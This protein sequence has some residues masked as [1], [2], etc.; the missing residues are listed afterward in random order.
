MVAG[1]T[2]DPAYF[3]GVVEDISERRAAEKKLAVFKR[4]I[5]NAGEA[6]GFATLDGRIEYVNPSL[7]RLLKVDSLE[8]A[9]GESIIPFYPE[10]LQEKLTGEVLPMTMRD[11]SWRGEL[12]IRATDGRV[13]PTLETYFIID[14]DD[15]EP[16]AHG[17]VMVDL[18]EQTGS[19]CSVGS[20]APSCSR[21]ARPTPRYSTWFARRSRARSACSATSTTTA[22]WSTRP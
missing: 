14:D 5:E 22:T 4:L 9:A 15:G 17:D 12:A 3:I 6:I 2:G 13:I 11:G 20:T 21:T 16:I 10:E 7:R 19:S 1:E 18:R 8:Q